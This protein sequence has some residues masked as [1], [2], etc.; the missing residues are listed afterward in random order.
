MLKKILLGLQMKINKL[1]SIKKRSNDV[2]I[3]ALSPNDRLSEESS[4]SHHE[5]EEYRRILRSTLSNDRIKNIAVTGN[6]GVGKSSIIRSYERIDSERCKGYLYVSLMDFSNIGGTDS[7]L[8]ESPDSSN[9]ESQKQIQQEFE[10]YLL[11]QILSRVDAKVIKSSIFRLIPTNNKTFRILCSALVALLGLCIYALTF[12]EKLNIPSQWE[13]FIFYGCALFG[14]S[15]LLLLTG[16]AIKSISHLKL[17][18]NFKNVTAELESKFDTGSYIDNHI[19]EMVYVLE[20]I[21]FDIGYTVV[22][23][24]MDR[25]G[26]KICVDIFSKLRRINYLVNDRHKIGNH[27]IRFIYAFDDS[28]FEL[29]KNT[30][31]FDYVISITPKLNYSTAGTL[32]ERL[33]LKSLPSIDNGNILEKIIKRY[34]KR[35]WKLVGLVVHDYRMLNHIRNDFLLFANVMAVRNDESIGKWLPFIIYKNIL[36]EDY[37]HAFEAKG[38]FELSKDERDERIETLCHRDGSNYSNLVTLLIDYIIDIIGFNAADFQQFTG[39]PSEVVQIRDQ[40]LANSWFEE[41]TNRTIN[42]ND[43]TVRQSV[44]GNR[45][46]VTGGGG[47]IGSELCRQIAQYGPASLIIIDSSENNAYEIQQELLHRFGYALELH[48][49]IASVKDQEKMLSIFKHYRPNIVFHAAA[50]KFVP[51]LEKDPEE[52]IRTNI[53]GT[54]YTMIAAKEV[55]VSKYV[56]VSTDKAVNPT[57]VMGAT[58][59]FAEMLIQSYRNSSTTYCAVRFGNTIG[60]S[61]SIIP[62]FEHQIEN[63]GPITITDR[64]IVRYFTTLPEACMSILQ[65]GA[66][67]QDNQIYVV[68]MGKPIKILDIAENL[69]RQ[70]GLIPNKDIEIVEVGLR[71]GEKLYD[72]LITSEVPVVATANKMIFIVDQSAKEQ[73]QIEK[74][75][76]QLKIALDENVSANELI[77]LLSEVVPEYHNPMSLNPPES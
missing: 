14:S 42:T 73:N 76:D 65:A 3:I 52:A 38:V 68:D 25:L 64:R 36:A 31:F 2:D 70:K 7:K 51:F 62:L 47:S 11:C 32:F 43:E 27:I 58:K 28:V 6:H 66:G 71:P 20:T 40:S 44:S 37:C 59:R 35:F 9:P 56:F 26:Q 53:F 21:A 49:E 60:K 22:L 30:K 34:D 61:G 23:E 46:V 33:I 17:S 50:L 13:V 45:V 63:G 5:F 69:I 10:R 57:N 16:V 54:Y 8:T 75:L 1:L 67:A 15:V 39:L 29:T 77:A 48:V 24:D 41:L 19:F 74:E 12:R 4:D 18:A 72:E 55:G